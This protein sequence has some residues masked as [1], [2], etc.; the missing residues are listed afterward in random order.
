MEIEK[1]YTLKTAMDEQRSEICT[2]TN[3]EN[4]QLKHEFLIGNKNSTK[5][6]D[7]RTFWTKNMEYD[8]FRGPEI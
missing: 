1:K 3:E 8:L 2:K 4:V 6:Y 5:H 7:L